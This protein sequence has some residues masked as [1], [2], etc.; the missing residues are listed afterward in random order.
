MGKER[1]KSQN[2]FLTIC[3]SSSMGYRNWAL[4]VCLELI[5]FQVMDSHS[6]HMRTMDKLECQCDYLQ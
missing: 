3:S 6:I 2:D 5:R 4:S 1:I